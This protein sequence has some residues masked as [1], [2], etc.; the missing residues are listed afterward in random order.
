[1]KVLGN[2][3]FIFQEQ[4]G[5]GI[6]RSPGQNIEEEAVVSLSKEGKKFVKLFDI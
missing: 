3:L 5:V 6:S 1:M 4:A 2:V